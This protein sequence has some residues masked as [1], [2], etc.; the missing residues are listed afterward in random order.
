MSLQ[1]LWHG[2]NPLPRNF[3]MKLVQE[4]KKRKKQKQ[5]QNT[6]FLEKDSETHFL[7]I[8]IFLPKVNVCI[9]SLIQ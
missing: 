4:K 6:S 1:Q 3:H 7:G 9:H 8:Q 2:F 5:K